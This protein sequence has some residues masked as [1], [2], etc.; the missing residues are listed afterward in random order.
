[1][2]V[3][4]RTPT[5]ERIINNLHKKYPQYKKAEIVHIVNSQYIYVLYQQRQLCTKPIHLYGLATV[6]FHKDRLLNYITKHN[7]KYK[8]R[9]PA[10]FEDGHKLIY[11]DGKRT[12]K[13][14]KE[15]N[16]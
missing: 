7:P 5:I 6:K 9:N 3:P 10:C 16:P 4:S 14:S 13:K 15:T 11:G 12:I 1:M 8:W 2:E